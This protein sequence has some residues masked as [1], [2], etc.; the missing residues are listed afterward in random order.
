MYNGSVAYKLTDPD[1]L[2]VGSLTITADGDVLLLGYPL[3]LTKNELCIL[4]CIT[5]RFPE[6][7]AERDILSFGRSIALKS[8]PVHINAI[9]RK[10]ARISGRRLIVSKRN[11][12]YILN[13]FM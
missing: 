1:I 6:Y 13:E 9:N 7:S 10:A 5:S 12:G 3:S 11:T 8:I 2:T 4:H